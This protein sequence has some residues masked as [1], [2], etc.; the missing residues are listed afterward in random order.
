MIMDV[1]SI[2][3]NGRDDS[4]Q[5][6]TMVSAG[7]VSALEHIELEKKGKGEA[8]YATKVAGNNPISGGHAKSFI[9]DEVTVLEE[10]IILN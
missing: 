10:D 8:S 3:G 7:V 5:Y 6:E 2:P 9:E 1:E 4:K